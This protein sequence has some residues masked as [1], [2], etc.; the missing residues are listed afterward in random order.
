MLEELVASM[1][2]TPRLAAV[3]ALPL[4]GASMA[5]EP[6]RALDLIADG[7]RRVTERSAEV[8]IL[9]GAGMAG[10]RSNDT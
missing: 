8:V 6:E 10:L 4:T 3:E 2:L 9:G 1:Q 7:V 5:A